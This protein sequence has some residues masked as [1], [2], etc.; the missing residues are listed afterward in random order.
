MDTLAGEKR[1]SAATQ[2]DVDLTSPVEFSKDA[3]HFDYGYAY[4]YEHG[5]PQIVGSWQQEQPPRSM[6]A[7]L[8][9]APRP[10][11][12][13][14]S[15]SHQS[16][17]QPLQ[18]RTATSS[19]YTGRGSLATNDNSDIPRNGQES[20]SYKSY[21]PYERKQR[22]SSESL[23]SI[24][25]SAQAE[26]RLPPIHTVDLSPVAESP[27]RKS[28]IGRSP[29]QYPEI[30]SRL[31]DQ[32]MRGMSPPKK[33]AFEPWRQADVEQDH[34]RRRKAARDS[35]SPPVVYNTT[36]NVSVADIVNATSKAQYPYDAQRPI[37]TRR[38][39]LAPAL[40][41]EVGSKKKEDWRVVPETVVDDVKS[42][43]WRTMLTPQ[44]I[45]DDLFLGV[46]K[47]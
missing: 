18:P 37:A 19:V 35:I 21:N 36:G 14:K 13:R 22:N 40:N 32:M 23:T 9:M 12:I 43:M 42:P 7:P 34:K 45:G 25:S 5:G 29:V 1:D 44:R 2:F 38:N 8:Q 31:S 47:Y 17:S 30:K 20:Q 41:I 24:E 15:Q 33:P 10:L 39:K 4:P 3:T 26:I 27:S 6:T 16:F 11:D 28:P 46:Q